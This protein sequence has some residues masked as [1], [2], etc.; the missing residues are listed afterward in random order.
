MHML[1][2]LQES[3][4]ADFGLNEDDQDEESGGLADVLQNLDLGQSAAR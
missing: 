3:D 4:E 1:R 2:R